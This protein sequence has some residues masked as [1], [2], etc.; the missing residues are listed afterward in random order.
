MFTIFHFKLDIITNHFQ[1]VNEI[2]HVQFL[3]ES[4]S[5]T[6]G[7]SLI[8]PLKLQQFPFLFVKPA[9]KIKIKIASLSERQ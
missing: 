7:K 9:L 3:I 1:A 5:L 2:N 4:L 6:C 8:S